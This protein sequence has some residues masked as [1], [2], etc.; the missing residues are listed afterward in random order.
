M[1]EH[2]MPVGKIA[3]RKPPNQEDL[4]LGDFRIT[5]PNF[6][7]LARRSLTLYD[8]DWVIASA[9]TDAQSYP[10]LLPGIHSYAFSG[11]L[12]DDER[13]VATY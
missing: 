7:G 8:V 2:P 10:V 11:V 3:Q 13:C 5:D 6:Y 4:K 12:R 9:G 1:R